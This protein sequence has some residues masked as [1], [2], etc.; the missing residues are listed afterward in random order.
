[1]ARLGSADA[2]WCAVLDAVVVNLERMG[3]SETVG[4]VLGL[5]ALSSFD[6]DFDF[7]RSVVR[8]YMAGAVERGLL[9]TAGLEGVACGV[10]P[11]GKLGIKMELNGGGFFTG[12]LDVGSNSSAGN[13]AAARD[14]DVT[15]LVAGEASSY[16]RETGRSRPLFKAHFDTVQLGHVLL[17]SETA[18]AEAADALEGRLHVYIGHLPEFD[19]LS[20]DV[21]GKNDQSRQLAMVGLDLLGDSRLVLSCKSKKLFFKPKEINDVWAGQVI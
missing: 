7:P 17:A 18:E 14:L 16:P 6:L 2:H 9:D 15:T 4:G 8:V 13:W 21:A 3:F 12:V 5:D 10:L 11:G 1:A 20:A 19:T